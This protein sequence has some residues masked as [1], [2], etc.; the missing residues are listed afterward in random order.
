MKGLIAVGAAAVALAAGAG[1]ASAHAGGRWITAQQAATELYVNDIE[2]DE[3]TD[4]VDY[5]ACRGI[6]AHIGARFKH[7]RCYVEVEEDD[8]YYVR[9]H[10]TYGGFV[11]DFLGYAE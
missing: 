10:S 8:A 4:T 2:W 1:T 5:A 3:G 6:G 7:F 9:L 11:A